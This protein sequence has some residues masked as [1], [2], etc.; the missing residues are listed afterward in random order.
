MKYLIFIATLIV[1]SVP[2]QA[3]AGKHHNDQNNEKSSGHEQGHDSKGSSEEGH[4]EEGHGGEGHGEEGHGGTHANAAGT[5]IGTDGSYDQIVKV[6][7]SDAMRIEYDQPLAL[8]PGSSIK[9]VVTNMGKIPHEFAISNAEEQIAH[10]Q[11]MRNM[12][13]MKH[14][15]G[16]TISLKSGQTKSIAWKFDGENEVVFS[17]NIPGHSEAGMLTKVSLKGEVHNHDH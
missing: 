13:N 16:S 11:M 9:F 10:V 7:L 1:M 14:E 6:S 2:V 15:D 5:P 4:G 12:P 3:D 17:C 8:K